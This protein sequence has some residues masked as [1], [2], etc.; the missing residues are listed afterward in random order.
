MLLNLEIEASVGSSYNLIEFHAIFMFVSQDENS[1]KNLMALSYC[2][3]EEKLTWN[4]QC[5]CIT[6]YINALVFATC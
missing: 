6:V 4:R 5:K 2:T 1:V 3:E